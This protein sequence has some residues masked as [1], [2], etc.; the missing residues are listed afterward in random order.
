MSK[1]SIE[2][3]I[4]ASCA[5]IKIP[6]ADQPEAGD[7]S[8]VSLSPTPLPIWASGGSS[9]KCM[10]YLIGLYYLDRDAIP[11][12]FLIEEAEFWQIYRRGVRTGNGIA[13]LF[14]Q[15]PLRD[16]EQ[17][18]KRAA[19]I[20]LREALEE[21]FAYNPCGAYR[22]TFVDL[23]IPLLQEVL[24]IIERNTIEGDNPRSA[25][26][27]IFREKG[28]ELEAEELCG[29]TIAQKRAFA[30]EVVAKKYREIAEQRRQPRVTPVFRNSALIFTK[31]AK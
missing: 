1:S 9:A 19:R 28:R 21:A 16:P 2:E 24:E 14:A 26:K 15:H 8:N 7:R 25:I 6:A 30:R 20:G 12:G 13:V 23:L 29:S 27:R 22:S 5:R 31:E 4:R 17:I 11:A 10:A 18:A 3:L